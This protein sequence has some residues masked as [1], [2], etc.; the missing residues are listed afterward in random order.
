M[1]P[2]ET[3][4]PEE[5]LVTVVKPGLPTLADLHVLLPPSQPTRKRSLTSD[6]VARGH[7]ARSSLPCRG[8]TGRS[9]PARQP[10]WLV[11][12]GGLT[13]HQAR[14]G[15]VLALLLLWL[16]PLGPHVASKVTVVGGG[17]DSRTTSPGAPHH[18][19]SHF[20]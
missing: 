17:G 15:W 8:A 18:L 12:T 3:S 6:K 20:I 11:G 2:Q 9:Q 5:L 19:L 14:S 10:L 16:H 1:S 13:S 4:V 7:S